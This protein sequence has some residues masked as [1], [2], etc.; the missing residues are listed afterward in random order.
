M[1]EI[2]PLTQTYWE[3]SG[4]AY[5]NSGAPIPVGWEQATSGGMSGSGAVLQDSEND[6]FH[7]IAYVNYATHMV[8]VAF[9]GT[10]PSNPT[11]LR[12]D[13]IADVQLALT[14]N[15]NQFSDA[16]RFF[17]QVQAAYSGFTIGL[18][19]HSLGGAMGNGVL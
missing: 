15:P 8:I 7:A 17:Q 5:P 9:R 6:G 18:T 2:T 19:G 3:F 4:L 13:L 12:N 10:D 11:D 1:T 16:I 14:G